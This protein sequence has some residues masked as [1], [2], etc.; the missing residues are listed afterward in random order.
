[1]SGLSSFKNFENQTTGCGDIAYCL[2]GYFLLSH[3]VHVHFVGMPF[4]IP[5]TARWEL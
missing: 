3:S 4:E 5:F 1:V 2:V